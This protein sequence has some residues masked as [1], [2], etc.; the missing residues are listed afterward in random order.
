MAPRTALVTGGNRGIGFSVCEQL[1]GLGVRVVLTSREIASGKK[2]AQRLKERGYDVICLQL[3]VSDQ[4]SVTECFA[5][6]ERKQLAIDVL[7]NNAGVYLTTPIAEASESEFM[8]ALQ[9][10]LLG[11]WRV[12]KLALPQMKRHNYGRIVNV[13][14][15]NGQFSQPGGPGPGA[16]GISKAGL[17]ALTLELAASVTGDIKI[18]AMCPGWVATRMGGGAAPRTP[19]QAADT[20]IWLATLGANGPNGG[21]FR[22]RKS[23]AW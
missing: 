1:A 14:S 13:S 4:S 9:V 19:E 3:D 20:I 10:N 22:D 23:I 12:A 2:A 5:K 8:H 6:L 21:F 18:N 15:G 11:A 7:V 17:N 16:Y